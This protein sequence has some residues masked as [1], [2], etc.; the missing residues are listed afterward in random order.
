MEKV[1]LTRNNALDFKLD[2]V[3]L[4]SAHLWAKIRQTANKYFTFN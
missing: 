3:I 1:L 4:S 2:I